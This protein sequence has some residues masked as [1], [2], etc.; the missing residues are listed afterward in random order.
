MDPLT[1]SL[2]ALPSI[3]LTALFAYKGYINNKKLGAAQEIANMYPGFIVGYR[4]DSRCN[5]VITHPVDRLGLKGT[6]GIFNKKKGKNVY[7]PFYHKGYEMNL[8]SMED[9]RL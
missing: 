1:T 6:V 8:R 7:L 3:S 9:P 4:L 2:I 5:I